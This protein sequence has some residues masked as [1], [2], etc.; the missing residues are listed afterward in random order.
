VRQTFFIQS[1]RTA[2]IRRGF[3]LLEVLVAIALLGILLGS[4]YSF[5]TTLFDRETRAI[6]E[7]NRSQ[8]A[9]MVYD[10]LEADLMNAIASA[11][12]SAGLDGTGDR[13][14]IAHR[15]VLVAGSEG[16]ASDLQT[17]TITFDTRRQRLVL[18]RGGDASS[19]PSRAS[20]SAGTAETTT[21][22]PAPYP[23]PIRWIRFRYH[24]GD[25]WRDRYTSTRSMPAAVELAIWFGDETAVTPGDEPTLDGFLTP[26]LEGNTDNPVPFD[27]RDGS[28]PFA[29]GFGMED[30]FPPELVGEEAELTQPATPPDRVRLITIPDARIPRFVQREI[31]AG[32][33]P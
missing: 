28:N 26:G 29:P 1:R 23:V 13:L 11:G 3:S 31:D 30:A 25:D 4:V 15:S 21:D 17:T 24:D 32:G 6:D 19:G 7:A 33:M 16:P 12:D 2:R 18:D 10:R 8:V 5:I 22:S 27:P 9:M 14:T 20:G